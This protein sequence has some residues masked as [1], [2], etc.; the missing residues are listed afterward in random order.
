MNDSKRWFITGVSSGFGRL[1]AEA[2]LGRGDSVVGT[3]RNAEQIDQFEALA[4]G[5]A[6]AIV[7][8]VTDRKRIPGA[9]HD[10]VSTLG[11]LDILVNNAGY[12]LAGALEELDEDEIDHAIE[13]NLSGTIYVTK[14]ALPALRESKGHI[15]NFSSMAGLVGLPG[16]AAY[17]AAKHG[18]EGFSESLSGEL[19]P[20]GISVTLIEPGG[21][22]T[23]FFKGSERIARAPLSIYDTTPAGMTRAGLSGAGD[24]MPG[25]PARAIGAILIAVDAQHPPLRLVLGGDALSSVRSKLESV[26]A[27]LAEWE[28]VT[29]STGFPKP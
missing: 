11:G 26:S 1:L 8:D 10:G 5:R 13:T 17:C 3:L 14:A 24:L 23:N 20:F 22:R 12:G 16:M 27:N 28:H 18:V 7:L 9:I 25:D 2:A 6:H 29:L 21:F 4:P 15:L 19:K